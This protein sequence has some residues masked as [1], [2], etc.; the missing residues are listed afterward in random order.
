MISLPHHFASWGLRALCL[1]LIAKGFWLFPIGWEGLRHAPFSVGILLAVFFT[2]LASW[3]GIFWRRGTQLRQS[4]VPFPLALVW[5]SFR[6]FLDAL[7][8]LV[9]A[10][11]IACCLL[12]FWGEPGAQEAV[13]NTS[14]GSHVSDQYATVNAL[15]NWIIHSSISALLYAAGLRVDDS[16]DRFNKPRR[17]Y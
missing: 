1:P 9:L 15:A 10:L 4:Q 5:L 7:A 13:L 14:L 8:A 2:L 17:A 12:V 6:A 3:I 16:L 11:G